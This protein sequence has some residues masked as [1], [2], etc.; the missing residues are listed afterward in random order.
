MAGLTLGFMLRFDPAGGGHALAV[1]AVA[2]LIR[3]VIWFGV[4]ALLERVP[5]TNRAR[6]A[7]TSMG[8]AALLVYLLFNPGFGN[9]SLAVPLWVM[10][11]LALNATPSPVWP[12]RH[13]IGMILPAPLLG[14]LCLLFLAVVFYPVA[15]AASSVNERAVVI[16]SGATRRSRAGDKK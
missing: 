6:V 1:E 10:A 15:S 16:R 9:P 5:W 13:W 2:A 11:A 14:V 8:V 12:P 7:A 3:F 4:F